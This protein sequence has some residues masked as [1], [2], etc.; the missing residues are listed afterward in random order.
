MLIQG[1]CVEVMAGME[2]ESVD[3]IVTDLAAGVAAEHLVCADLILRGFIAIRTDQMCSYD[4]AV[5]VAGRLVRVQVKAT[6]RPRAIPQR[7]THTPAYMWY[8]RRAGKGGARV[9]AAGEFDILALVALD[10]RRVAYLPP[11][12]LRQTIHIRQPGTTAGNAKPGK[13]FEDY[14]FEAAAGC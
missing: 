2:L 3:A 5:E 9:Y 11:S 10:V 4:V 6:R 13:R 14:P 12:L 8:V 7:A 1:D